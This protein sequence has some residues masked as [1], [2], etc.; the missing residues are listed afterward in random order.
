MKG[1]IVVL[2][3]EMRR[4]PDFCLRLRD[5]CPFQEKGVCRS[6]AGGTEG[7]LLTNETGIQGVEAQEKMESGVLSLAVV[8]PP[9]KNHKKAAFTLLPTPRTCRSE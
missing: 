5:V 4:K 1:K 7:E 3:S 6:S 9:T 2:D 8:D